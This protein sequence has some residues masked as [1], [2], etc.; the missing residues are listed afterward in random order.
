MTTIDKENLQVDASNTATE[1]EMSENEVTKAAE[2]ENA[3]AEESAAAVTKESA[4]AAAASETPAS[5]EEE[6]TQAP[7]AADAKRKADTTDAPVPIPPRPVKRA[8]TAY[9]IFADDRRA[10]IQAKVRLALC[11]FCLWVYPFSTYQQSYYRYLSNHLIYLFH[12][13]S[14]REKVSLL[15]PAN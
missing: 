15:W 5:Q 7:D 6:K 13:H 4:A 12:I 3:Q 14:T 8:R 10:A 1:P 11:P 2:P 9:F